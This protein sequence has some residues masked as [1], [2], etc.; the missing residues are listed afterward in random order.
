[1]FDRQ[2]NQSPHE[3]WWRYVHP[4]I[5]EFFT[6]SVTSYRNTQYNQNYIGAEAMAF[7]VLQLP[8]ELL[9]GPGEI[10]W[11]QLEG[12]A[13]QVYVTQQVVPT[14]IAGIA[15]GQLW[16]AGL[17]DNPYANGQNPGTIL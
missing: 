8:L 13:P 7:D 15:S 12:T 16:E 1:M 3:K 6:T 17:Q 4:K 9:K 11:R 5:R 10:V 2:N 14:G